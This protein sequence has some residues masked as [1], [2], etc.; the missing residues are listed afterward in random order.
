LL[1]ALGYSPVQAI[2]TSSTPLDPVSVTAD[3]GEKPQSK[4]WRHA[5]AWWCVL[6]KDS[7]SWILKL[8]GTQWIEVLNISASTSTN[9]DAKV[10]GDIVHILLYQGTTSQLASAEYVAATG[11]YQPW[12]LRPTLS[13][14]NLDSFV[15]TATI[16]IDSQDRMWL[17][18]DGLRAI[19]I[20]YSDPRYATWSAPITIESSVSTDDICVVTAIP[21][22]LIGVMWSNQL[23]KRF[24]FKT[25]MDGADPNTWSADEVP[26][27]QSA[28]DY[29]GDGMADDHINVAVASDGTLYAAVKTEYG[30]P[31]F[32]VLA[33]LV[34]HPGGAW[35]DLYDVTQSPS[36]TRPIV[37]L[38]ETTD[39]L[40]VVYR[41]R[42]EDD[43]DD[44]CI[45]YRQ[46]ETS[47][48]SFTPEETLI[49]IELNNPTSTKQ[50]VSEE[51]VVLASTD[52][53]VHGVLWIPGSPTTGIAELTPNFDFE[54]AQNR[55]NPFNPTTTI[56]FEILERTH[57]NLSIFDPLGRRIL[58]LID[59]PRG[60]G[61][62]EVVWDGTDANGIQVSSGV[63][64]YRLQTAKS[65]RTKKMLL[66]K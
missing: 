13:P 33:L 43:D 32:P 4:V 30:T 59:A 40:T 2:G 20:R 52:V 12:T 31:G 11:L 34:R 44:R 27:S 48:I 6:S 1:I 21:S 49:D 9:A 39:T 24:G 15:E 55:P 8:Q 25:H 38:N 41:S 3:T 58:T 26:A 65:A 16:D 22:G 18:S 56:S 28:N 46:S 29:I 64:F 51:A 17:A 47:F 42:E 62:S 50:N 19:N 37:L 5:G 54:L 14:I 23:T 66:L 60:P 45:D 35:D 10:A 36:A 7:G 61:V 63:Y 53:V 57:V